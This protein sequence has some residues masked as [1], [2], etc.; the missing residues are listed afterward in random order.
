[1]VALSRTCRRC[2]RPRAVAISIS[3]TVAYVDLGPAAD[4]LPLRCGLIDLDLQSTR[5]V[6]IFCPPRLVLLHIEFNQP[7]LYVGNEIAPLGSEHAGP[8]RIGAFKFQRSAAKL[9]PG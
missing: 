2:A 7:I 9:V 1:M 5:L 8:P 6:S 4:L 3:R